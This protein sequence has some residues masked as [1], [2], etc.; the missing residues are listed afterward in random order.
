M[1]RARASYL[2]ALERAD[3]ASSLAGVVRAGEALAALS[4]PAEPGLELSAQR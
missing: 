4:D 2:L 1:P 3:R